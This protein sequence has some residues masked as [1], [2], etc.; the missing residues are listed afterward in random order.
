MKKKFVLLTDSSCD[1]PYSFLDDEQIKTVSLSFIVNG[2]Q[3]KD[4]LGKSVDYKDFYNKI[5]SGEMPSTS[6]V[7]VYQFEEIFKLILKDGND[8]I[9]I[10]FSSGLSGSC[11]NA[12]NAVKTLKEEFP[13]RKIA[14]VDSLCASMGQGLLL[15]Y[16]IDYSNKGMSFE[17]TVSY[18]ENMKL[19]ISHW[20]TVDDLK[21]LHRGGRVSKATAVIGSLMSIK[22]VLNVD[23]EGHLIG[24]DKVRGRKQA[25]TALVDKLEKYAE[26]I[27]EG[28][29]FISHGDCYEEA[30]FVADLIKERYNYDKDILIN[31]VGPVIGSHSGPGTVALFFISKNREL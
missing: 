28:R 13:D 11:Q 4:D 29:I 20:F 24:R 6:Q 31:Y 21:F 19:K 14:V 1:L 17:D 27:N 3:T 8:L 22:P 15:S 30:K 2:V 23:R 18:A 5:R 9:Y 12:V 26:N 25:L 16:V 10:A 7:N